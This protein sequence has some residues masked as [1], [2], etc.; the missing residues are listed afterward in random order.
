MKLFG[1]A[2]PSEVY[3]LH[4]EVTEAVVNWE[5]AEWEASEYE[6]QLFEVREQNKKLQAIVKRLQKTVQ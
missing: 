2:S 3:K 5:K 1:W 4:R 6:Q